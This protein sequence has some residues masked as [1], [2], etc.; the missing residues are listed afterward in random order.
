M[1][2]AKECNIKNLNIV[3]YASSRIYCRF[4]SSIPYME[5]L[6]RRFKQA[7]R[8]LIPSRQGVYHDCS[9]SKMKHGEFDGYVPVE[10][11]E[12][13]F[14]RSSGPGGQNNLFSV[15]SKCQIRF[16]LNEANWLSLEIRQ[17]FRKRYPHLLN[18]LEDVVISAD[19]SRVQAENQVE[20]IKKLQ[21]MLFECNKEFLKNVP[22]TDEDQKILQN[23]AKKA[24]ERRLKIKQR[25]SEKKKSRCLYE[26][27]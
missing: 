5:F 4:Y 20:C 11:I 24:S 8:L 10:R 23:R 27:F 13:R 1:I 7:V 16:N 26:I 3:L 17:I 21:A 22:P 9:F 6:A 25:L 2:L 19:K 18:K 15:N 14:M 12:K